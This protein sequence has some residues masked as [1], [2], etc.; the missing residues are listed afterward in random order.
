MIGLGCV[1][2]QI[3][4]SI[5]VEEEVAGVAGLRADDIGA[6]NGI[7]AE[8][9]G[10]I[11]A[12]DVVVAFGGVELDGKATG[13]AAFVGKLTAKGDGRETGEDGGLFTHAGEEVGFLG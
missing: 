11:E 2:Q 9:D 1:G 4:E 13:V 12:H 3:K 6:L 7:A 8:E 5:I 10:E